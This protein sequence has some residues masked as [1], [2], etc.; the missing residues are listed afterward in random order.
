M[1]SLYEIVA[2]ATVKAGSGARAERHD[3]KRH[4]AETTKAIVQ[5]WRGRAMPATMDFTL[6]VRS[7]PFPTF[8]G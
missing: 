5:S 8:G 1:V 7:G 3:V 4:A 2:V 6:S